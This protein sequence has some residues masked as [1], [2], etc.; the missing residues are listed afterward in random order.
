LYRRVKGAVMTREKLM[1][2]IVFCSPQWKL[3]LMER[4]EA[5]VKECFYEHEMELKDKD[6]EIAKLND[7][8]SKVTYDF[9]TAVNEIAELKHTVSGLN[10]M[11]LE[12]KE[13]LSLK[14]KIYLK[15]SK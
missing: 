3:S 15:D 13:C 11:Y 4:V 2:E 12:A 7:A 9:E 5:S 10:E 6:E 8:Y 14:K 1:E